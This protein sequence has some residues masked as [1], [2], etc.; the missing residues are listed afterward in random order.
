MAT[1][2]LGNLRKVNGNVRKEVVYGNRSVLLAQGKRKI[3]NTLVKKE[4]NEIDQPRQLFEKNYKLSK[5]VFK[6]NEILLFEENCRITIQLNFEI[7]R[8]SDRFVLLP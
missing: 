5:V 3:I 2:Q 8:S 4:K 1:E 6:E 7:V